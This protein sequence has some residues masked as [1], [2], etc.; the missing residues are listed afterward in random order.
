MKGRAVLMLLAIVF[1]ASEVWA[2]F[3]RI[4]SLSPAIT[5][6]IYALEAQDTLIGVSSFCDYPREA[7][8]KE[9]VGG[10]IN[11]NL[12]KIIALRPD[13]V[14]LSPNSGTK[15]IH[16]RLEAIGITTRVVSFYTIEELRAAYRVIGEYTERPKNAQ[17]LIRQL[18]QAINENRDAALAERP[19]VLFVRSHSPLFV[20]GQGTYE[21]DLIRI[22]GGLNCIQKS[23]TRYP[24]YAVEAI[25][26]ID[27]EIVIDAT[28]Y[29]TPS[30]QQKKQIRTFWSQMRS[31]TAVKNKRVY[32]IETDIHSVPGPRTPEM[33]GIMAQI[34]TGDINRAGHARVLSIME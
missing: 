26:D 25:M 34:L 19:R 8:N 32:I 1:C 9:N 5:E 17:R 20:A 31:V 11:P 21:D 7:R 24:Q 23:A 18:E 12:E 2:S 4:I 30:A 27:P 14:I 22:V 29:D 6:I 16:H 13:L 15:Q 33:L 3:E 28:F 10:F